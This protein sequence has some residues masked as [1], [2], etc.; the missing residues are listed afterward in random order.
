MEINTAPAVEKKPPKLRWYQWRLRTMFLLT[1]VVAIGMSYM[2]VEMRN[3]RIQW[4]AAEQIKKAGGSVEH[5]RTRLGRF[6]Q[7]DSLVRVVR[8]QLWN[9][10]INDESLRN[11]QKLDQLESLVLGGEQVT[12]DVLATVGQ[13]TQLQSLFVESTEATDA[14]LAHLRTLKELRYLDLR[15]PKITDTGLASVQELRQLRDLI[16]SG[17]PI[18]DDGLLQ[19]KVLYQLRWISLY[20]TNVTDEDLKRLKKAMPSCFIEIVR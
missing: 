2:A 12:D 8:V 17:V 3:Q 16:L 20:K 11:L 6:L 1:L 4:A 10:S 13:M 7:D 9:D 14:G 19:L 5:Q 15:R 18:S